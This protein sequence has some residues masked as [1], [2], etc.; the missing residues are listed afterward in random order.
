VTLDDPSLVREQYADETRLAVRK[1]AHELGEGPDAREVVFAAVRDARPSRI[2]DVG[3]GEGELAER[4]SRELPAEVVAIDQSE[5]MVEI[6]ATRGVDA[7]VGDVRSLGFEDAEFDCAVAA[8]M[9]FHV[10]DLDGALGELARVL[11]PGGR[12]VAA[13]NGPD[14]LR[15]LYEL[16]GAAPFES[17]FNSANAEAAL[18]RHFG[19][20]ERIDARGWIVFPTRRA[21]QDYIDSAISLAGHRI[22]AVEGPIR[23]RRT[24]AIF[25]AEKP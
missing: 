10:A 11:R 16:A 2:L 6:A 5:R 23:A 8:W 15:E 21:A 25:V 7:R 20:I 24:P 19:R 18:L 4:M 14:H 9:L 17:R 13:T 1:R 3:C 22:D 12:L